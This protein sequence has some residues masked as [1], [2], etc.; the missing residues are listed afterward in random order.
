MSFS[1][2]NRD[3]IERHVALCSQARSFAIKL[4]VNTRFE[5]FANRPVPFDIEALRVLQQQWVNRRDNPPQLQYEP[6]RLQDWL[7]AVGS[8]AVCF[9]LTGP[10]V[11][12]SIVA[13]CALGA[14]YAV[15][16][17]PQ[18]PRETIEQQW[19]REAVHYSESLAAL[20]ALLEPVEGAID[21]EEVLAQC[22]RIVE[23]H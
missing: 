3:E 1:E 6:P 22:R 8:V 13:G 20:L 15:W 5:Q 7:P 21:T 17:W 9:A 18:E 19:A 23:F 10:L 16:Q 2:S 12:L 11:A 14:G 4:E